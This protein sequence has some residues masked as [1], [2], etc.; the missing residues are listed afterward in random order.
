[1]SDSDSDSSSSSSSSLPS[2]IAVIKT[3]SSSSKAKSNAQDDPTDIEDNGEEWDW[4]SFQKDSE[5]E[6]LFL[7]D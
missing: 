6:L 3:K 7:L 4:G 2:K 5:L 1:M